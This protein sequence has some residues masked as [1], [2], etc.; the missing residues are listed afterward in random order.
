VG[1]SLKNIIVIGG[2]FAGLSAGTFLSEKGFQVVVLEGRQ[3]PGGRAYSFRDPQT[4]DSVDNGQHLF[5][6]CYHETRRFLERIGTIDLLQFQ[7]NLSV[8]FVGN[9]G[10]EARLGCLPLPAPLHILSGLFSL[11]T[12][13]FNDRLR[14]LKMRNALKQA[15]SDP[16]SAQA[17][18]IDQWLDQ[19]GQ[20]EEVRRHLW[21]LI[22]IAALNEDPSIASAWPFAVV[23]AQAFFGG[24]K[25]SRL[26]FS[27]VGLS[28]LYVRAAKSFIEEKGGEIREKAPVERLVFEGNR[29]KSVVL[30]D[31]VRLSADWVISAVPAAS[32]IRML[33]EGAFKKE[34]AF[35][36]IRRLKT[37][38][39]ISIHLWFDR[40]ISDKTFAGLLDTHIQ[41]FF[42]KAK[43]HL[44]PETSKGSVSLVISG[45]H[46]FIEWP[47]KT[48]L[49]MSMEELRRLF[50]AA[51]NAALVRWMIIK[52][53]QA[54]LS[55]EVGSEPLRPG[56]QTAY[57]NL[58]LAGDWTRTGLPATIESACLSGHS[59]AAIIEKVESGAEQLVLL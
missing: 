2:G 39:I 43:I 54:T 57:R 14:I 4:H 35:E 1:L 33:P 20:S 34:P 27:T 10:R 56:H 58:L 22:A 47:D 19:C 6:G 55:P 50:P 45:A 18:T 26:G 28:D 23:L 9:G 15:I 11:S 36:N 16:E 12:L 8:D 24:R 17:L 3:M 38:P 51:R 48:I 44:D 32:L 46:K 59:C 52:E 53:N 13:S 29:V 30:R 7:N 37:A 42:N 31:G 21:D 25:E 5:M 40:P 41:W 49:A